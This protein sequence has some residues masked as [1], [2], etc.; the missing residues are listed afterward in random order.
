MDA[1]LK[2]Q[3]KKVKLADYDI[4]QTLG[5]GSYATVKLAKNKSSGKFCT[6]KIFKKEEIIRKKQVEHLHNELKILSM[7]DYAFIVKY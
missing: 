6:I 2:V 4:Q 1:F 5:I 3:P 7:L